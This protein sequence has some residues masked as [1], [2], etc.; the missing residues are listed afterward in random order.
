MTENLI[1]IKKDTVKKKLGN[2]LGK[3]LRFYIDFNRE[4]GLFWRRILPKTEEKIALVDVFVGKKSFFLWL[5]SFIRILLD[6]PITALVVSTVTAAGVAGTFQGR[7]S[8]ILMYVI[9]FNLL[10]AMFQVMGWIDKLQ[11]K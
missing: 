2:I 3:M 6:N 8:E 1:V 7:I 11:E 5:S 9:F 4:I 10:T